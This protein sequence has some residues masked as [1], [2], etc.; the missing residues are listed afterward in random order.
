MTVSINVENQPTGND[1]IPAGEICRRVCRMMD[2]PKHVAAWAMVSM[3]EASVDMVEYNATI[4]DVEAD[5][6]AANI[7]E[8]AKDFI[9]DMLQEFRDSVHKAIQDPEFC[10]AVVKR[11]HFKRDDANSTMNIDDIEVE[12][13][14]D[15]NGKR[16]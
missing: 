15:F 3:A 1:Q 7:R 10:A 14:F 6:T 2:N 4:M 11:I 16:R 9:E 8:R 13:N 12:L 5:L